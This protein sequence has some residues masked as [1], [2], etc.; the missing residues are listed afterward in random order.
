MAGMTS[1]SGRSYSF[2]DRANG[3]CRGEGCA[4]VVLKRLGDAVADGDGI[5][6][7]LR[8]SSVMQDGKSASLTAPNGLAQQDLLLT[9]L[10]DAQLSPSDVAYVEAHGTGTP[11]GDPIETE[12]I[13]AVY[14]EDRSPD[15]PLQ[16]SSIK[17]NIGHLEAGAGLAGVLSAIVALQHSQAPP[18]AQLENMNPKV[19]ATVKGL[20]I[21]F[22]MEP[23]PLIRRRDDNG[24]EQP[25]VAGVSS[26]GFSG[27]I[28][29][30]LL[31]EAPR[32]CV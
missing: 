17:A 22:P 26:F 31:E 2:D 23:T 15:N 32:N 6:A 13:A 3:Y 12:A 20:P 4:A 1:S 10:S 28:A 24:T 19:A 27:T 25:L 29:H 7:V 21:H 18:N 9:C 16:V 5:H 8:G 14:G 30:V 11:L